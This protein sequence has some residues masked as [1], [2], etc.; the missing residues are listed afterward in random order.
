[1]GRAETAIGQLLT[2]PGWRGLAHGCFQR[3][4]PHLERLI[5]LPRQTR[6]LLDRLEIVALHHVKVMEDAFRLSAE[7]RLNLTPDALRGT[8]GVVH[9]T[10]YFIEE[11]IRRLD[12][13]CL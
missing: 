3:G 7:Q 4:N 11:T 13:G 5:F 9:Q 12:H 1:M 6:H 10:G 8:G 2:V